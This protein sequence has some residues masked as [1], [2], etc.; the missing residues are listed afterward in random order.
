MAEIGC[1]IAKDSGKGD[2]DTKDC[3]IS[4]ATDKHAEEKQRVALLEFKQLNNYI[5]C[6]QSV[7]LA[8]IP[9]QRAYYLS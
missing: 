3:T 8:K 9:M 7:F 2:R 5:L 6:G 1:L 4:F